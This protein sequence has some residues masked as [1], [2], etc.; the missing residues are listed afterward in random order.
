MARNRPNHSQKRSRLPGS[1]L[2]DTRSLRRPPVLT[3][4]QAPVV[5]GKAFIVL[6]DEQKNT[7]IYKAGAWV[8]HSASIK[9][10]R[11]TCQVKQLPQRVNKMIRY[12]I[13]CPEGN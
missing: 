13:R 7:F 6:E 1:A 8:P 3:G 11:E 10:C 12:E 9:E 5:Y 4:R 2:S